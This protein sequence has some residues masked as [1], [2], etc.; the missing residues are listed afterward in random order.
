MPSSASTTKPTDEPAGD[1]G[2][3]KVLG[4]WSTLA[5]GVGAMVGFGWITLAGGWIEDGGSIGAALAMLAGGLMMGVIALVYSELLSAMPKAGGEHHYIL[6]ALGPRW[7]FIG[8]W[9]ITGGY[10]T[11][12]A[13]EAVALPKSIQYVVD[14]Q[15]IPLWNIGESEVFLI[16]ALVGAG[17][18][19]LITVIN[20]MGVRV[21]GG[22]QTFVILFL[23]AIGA[24]QVFGAATAGDVANMQPLFSGSG[25]AGFLAVLVVV[26]FM[27]VGFDV[28]PQA[29]EEVN[30]PPRRV[31]RLS[32]IAVL[33]AAAWYIM[34]ILTV[35]LALDSARTAE[36]DLPTAD[37]MGALLGSRTWSNVMI[38]A[39][40][41]GIITSWNSLQMG[42]SRLIYSL[43]HSGML[44]AWLGRLHPRYGTPV[45]AL[46]VLGGIAV[47]APFLGTEA[48]GWIVGSG[49][50]MIVIAYLLVSISFVVLRRREPDMERPLRIG[51]AG[52]GGVWIGVAAVAIT[53]F[54]TALYLPGMPA[55][56]EPVS[57]L[58]FG[59]WWLAGLFF[60]LRIPRGVPPGPGAEDELRRR[61]GRTGP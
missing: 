46:L 61:A 41:A 33:I 14:L 8:S 36:A 58:I 21:A 1:P 11:V 22:V 54:L 17:T 16:W 51:G 18:A 38:A 32:F 57:W 10:A 60:L 20:I 12:V 2:L 49:S 55:Q 27:F 9:G 13:F 24:L 59:G 28:I 43:A 42:A 56:I 23:F 45:N 50:P 40:L 5:L 53:A 19:V 52:G 34:I 6:R 35:S 48:L 37:A 31:G 7:S 3:K 30:L 25:A 47:L 39:G 29:A 26:P 4:G 44:P 15:H